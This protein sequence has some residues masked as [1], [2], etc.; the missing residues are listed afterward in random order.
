MLSARSLMLLGGVFS[1]V[2]SDAS[3]AVNT[4]GYSAGDAGST[5]PEQIHLAM[6]SSGS[7]SQL[8]ITYTT[9]AT[10]PTYAKYSVHSNGRASGNGSSVAAERWSTVQGWSTVY[11]LSGPVNMAYLRYVHRVVFPVLQP[12]TK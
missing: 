7:I 10:A 12:N 9:N 8:S 2:A 11:N 3:N 1:L 5:V 4:I 6:N